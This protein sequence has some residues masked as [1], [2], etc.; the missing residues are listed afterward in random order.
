M[1]YSIFLLIY[2]Q[3]IKYIMHYITLFHRKEIINNPKL[4]N[5]MWRLNS[6]E[7][8]SSLWMAGNEVM[9][10]GGQAMKADGMWWVGW[11]CFTETRKAWN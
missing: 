2:Y 4:R 3:Q 5:G 9:E 10:L 7:V 8:L 1:I 11:R 6:L